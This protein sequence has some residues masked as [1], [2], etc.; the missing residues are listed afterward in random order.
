MASQFIQG[1]GAPRLPQP[2]FC[3]KI[4][5]PQRFQA[6]AS[7]F[8]IVKSPPIRKDCFDFFQAI[9]KLAIQIF[10][11]EV[12]VKTFRRLLPPSSFQFHI[13]GLDYVVLRYMQHFENQRF[14]EDKFL[15]QTTT[16]IVA[17][18]LYI[19]SVGKIILRKFRET[20][21]M[22]AVYISD[23]IN[24]DQHKNFNGNVSRV[25]EALPKNI[26]R[27]ESQYLQRSWAMPK[28]TAN[29]ISNGNRS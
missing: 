27:V 12:S 14:L 28:D 26:Q 10:L 20:T 15:L 23:K 19:C 4:F 21:N 2:A 8:F 5:Q 18:F 24:H 11:A 13:H 29:A 7:P 22:K 3:R 17:L 1:G 25:Y 9:K 16:H 6:A